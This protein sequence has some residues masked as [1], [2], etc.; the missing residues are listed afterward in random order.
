MERWKRKEWKKILALTLAWVLF[1]G[2][3]F[4]GLLKA[5]VLAADGT[6]SVTDSVSTDGNATAGDATSGDATSGDATSGDATAGDATSGDA[7]AGD[8]TSG[9]ATSGDATA[10][11]A[12]AGDAT[13]GD[14]TAGDATSGDATPGDATSGDATPG[15]ES[16]EDTSSIVT[17]DTDAKVT[18]PTLINGAVTEESGEKSAPAVLEGTP[19][20]LTTIHDKLRNEEIENVEIVTA[21]VAPTVTSD[22]FSMAKDN[23]KDV[24]FTVVAEKENKYVVLYSWSFAHENIN[25]NVVESMQDMD[26][27]ISFKANE[28]TKAK[29]DAAVNGENVSNE[30]DIYLSIDGYHGQLPATASLKVY[31]GT[32]ENGSTV[33]LYYFNEETNKVQVMGEY[34][35]EA[36]YITVEVDH[37]SVYFVSK[38]TPEEYNVGGADNPG[39]V[40]D[41]D[42]KPDDGGNTDPKPDDGD[43]VD[44]QT[45]AG[46]Q[47]SDMDNSTKA[48]T[49]GNQNAE[50]SGSP[51]TGDSQMILIWVAM[52]LGSAAVLISLRKR[53]VN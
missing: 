8:A 48:P 7:T 50:G 41:T 2:A 4:S 47:T 22:F 20:D 9:D 53:K 49:L 45:T 23:G 44:D 43:N 36:G 35:V 31:V 38:N 40:D 1:L 21:T 25:E 24:T 6:L 29:I 33:Y 5:G 19:T 30:N 34:Q 18:E 13:A 10:G 46:N 32:Y 39:G 37:C 12:T 15:D 14:A 52:L 51:K 27:T 16:E 26:L 17:I 28:E 3:Q 11:D 42:P